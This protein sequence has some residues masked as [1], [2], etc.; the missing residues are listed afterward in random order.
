MISSILLL[1]ALQ[2]LWLHNSYEKAYSDFRGETSRLI[3]GAV[4]A[5]RDSAISQSIEAIPPDS[6]ASRDLVS[7]SRRDSSLQENQHPDRRFTQAQVYITSKTGADSARVVLRSI[8]SQLH[9]RGM[10]GSS[11]FI[12]R[13][14]QDS[15][16]TD[17]IR[18]QFGRALT[19]ARKQ[20]RFEI[21][22]MNAPISFGRTGPSLPGSLPGNETERTSPFLANQLQSEWVRVEPTARYAAV[23][24]DIRPTLLGEIAPQILFGIFLTLLTAASFLFMYRSILSQQRLMTIKNDFISN[25]THELKTP[26][27]TVSVALEALKNFKGIEDPKRTQEYLD[28]AQLE[29]S[30]LSILTD[31][32][33]TSS[34]LDEKGI[35]IDFQTVDLDKTIATILNSFKLVVEKHRAN[36]SFEKVGGDFM[37][38]GSSLH[39]TNVVYNLLDNAMKYSP[40]EP[41]INI[42]LQ[43]RGNQVVFSVTDKGLGIPSAYQDKV[44]E[45][46]FRM[47][48]GDVHNIKGYGLGLSYVD[49]VVK[50]HHG[51]IS[52]Q[53]APGEGS[54]FTVTLP[55]HR[56]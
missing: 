20:M 47:P 35:T 18:E 34:L 12:I 15:L 25:I 30:R 36:V 6:L 19:K 33:L 22:K 3:R 21:K 49:Q 7:A 31:K 39:L 8:A 9:D 42:L 55:K 40:S 32:V 43:D 52:L 45:K 10:R 4:L 53:S 54:T 11:Q 50:G 23:L 24:F 41:R 2:A 13:M 29:L 51:T 56:R 5:V 46:F 38:E 27:A 37:V 14:N 28:M 44:F 16:S 48:T 17:S 26:I 1:V